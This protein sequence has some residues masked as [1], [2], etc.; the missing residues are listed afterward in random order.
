MSRINLLISNQL[1]DIDYIIYNLMQNPLKQKRTIEEL[2]RLIGEIKKYK[3]SDINHINQSRFES[4]EKLIMILSENIDSKV[5][6]NNSQ[7]LETDSKEIQNDSKVNQNDSK[8]IQN[9]TQLLENDKGPIHMTIPTENDEL[10]D[11]DFKSERNSQKISNTQGEQDPSI[12]D[13]LCEL[14]N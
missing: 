10:Y 4:A 11:V 12:C 13:K 3:L 1:D 6:Q 5:N 14:I 7:L 9:D 8:E 2:Q